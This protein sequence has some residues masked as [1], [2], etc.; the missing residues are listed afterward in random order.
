MHS[1][2]CTMNKLSIIHHFSEWKVSRDD[3]PECSECGALFER[4]FHRHKWILKSLIASKR[5]GG[6]CLCWTKNVRLEF[7][8]NFPSSTPIKGFFYW[9]DLVVRLIIWRK[10]Q[11]S[12]HRVTCPAVKYICQT[13]IN[14]TP[15]T[16][17]HGQINRSCVETSPRHSCLTDK[18]NNYF[19]IIHGFVTAGPARMINGWTVGKGLE[20]DSSWDQIFPQAVSAMDES[21]NKLC[22]RRKKNQQRTKQL[23]GYNERHSSENTAHSRQP[24]FSTLHPL[25]RCLFG[26][27][28]KALGPIE[29]SE[30]PGGNQ[31][32]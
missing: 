13:N 21:S 9:L 30:W 14:K 20:F 22:E 24:H 19:A 29:F 17:D 25:A 4:V 16:F 10:G 5:F 1:K 15:K 28:L 6:M 2:T 31:S 8:I 11:M 12:S 3:V 32:L 7:P 27:T 18:N 23:Y 26:K